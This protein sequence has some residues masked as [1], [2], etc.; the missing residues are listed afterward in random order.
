VT[1]G[2][3]RVNR[4]VVRRFWDAMATNDFR[5]AADL[6]HDDYVLEWPQSRERIR[7]RENFV[8]VNERYPA[9]GRWQF[10]VRRI[11]ADEHEVVSQVKVTDGQTEGTAITF[12]QIRD[13]RIIRQTEYWPD[14][15]P[16]ATW[17]AAWVEKME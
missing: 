17:R 10:D 8:M 14:R 15:F 16:A 13:G 7:G 3:R 4:D 9:A 12:S 11:I 6:L 2:I 1:Q 5:V